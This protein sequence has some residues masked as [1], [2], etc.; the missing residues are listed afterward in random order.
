MIIPTGKY[1]GW[2]I[3]EVPSFYLEYL[4]Q[5][6]QDGELKE[7]ATKEFDK[8]TVYSTHYVKRREE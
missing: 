7:A 1:K 8:R 5:S 3:K 4:I 6:S 2:H